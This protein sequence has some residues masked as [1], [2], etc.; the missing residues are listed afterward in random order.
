MKRILAAALLIVMLFSLAACGGGSETNT[1]A[2]T[3]AAGAADT[4]ATE[5]TAP[6][7]TELTRENA[8]SSVPDMDLKGIVV[9]IG[10]VDK[11]R[12]IEDIIG[13]DNGDVVQE[14]V[15]MRNLEV[16]EKLKIKLE[17]VVTETSAS[18]TAQP[19]VNA[20]TAG[21]H[22]YDLY[23]GLQC[24]TVK[25]VTK[26]YFYNLINDKY[27]DYDAPWWN[28]D[29][30]KELHIGNKSRYF[31]FGDITNGLLRNAGCVYFNKDI[32]NDTFHKTADDIYNMVFEGKW[33]FDMYNEYVEKVY[34]DVNGNGEKDKGDLFG[35]RGTASKSVEHYQ[36]PAEIIVT[37]WDK[38]GKPVIVLNNE[39]TVQ[40]AEKLY[41]LYFENPGFGGLIADSEIDTTLLQGFINNETLF[42]PSWFYQATLLREM[43][44]D[45]GII[46]YPKLDEKQENY[47]SLVHNG[48]CMF[49]VP[50]TIPA[51][52]AD[53][54]GAVLEEMA[55]G[56]YK[57]ITPAYFDTALKEKYS[58]DSTSSQ[59]LE[60]IYAS[61][62]TNFGYCYSA[63]IGG[64]G[65]MRWVAGKQSKDV[66]SW[67]AQNEAAAQAGLQDLITHY[68]ESETGK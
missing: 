33:T 12:Y 50:I 27:I 64:I 58:R 57:R 44:S 18:S 65:T 26:G 52:R 43:E 11:Y 60:M 6:A 36:F 35:C 67:Y 55:V 3:T 48:C 30:M 15:Y 34:Q 38:D 25:H 23:N 42:L 68:L 17:P 45:Y 19:F 31:L 32:M 5:S 8:V 37:D 62:Y 39:R 13:E 63:L 28:M 10:Y 47:H 41:H 7:E 49:C 29:Y 61:A 22:L 66:A 54:I 1:P 46:P 53:V 9:K 51:E 40:F 24:Y 4:N 16:E 59:M 14:A 20:V 21:D 2:S 56:A